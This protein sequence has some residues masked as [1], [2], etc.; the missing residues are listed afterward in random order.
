MIVTFNF[1]HILF[2]YKCISHHFNKSLVK[3]IDIRF[4]Q[5]AD[6]KT[7]CII[8]GYISIKVLKNSLVIL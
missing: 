7:F 8:V 4:D 6:L 2:D 1:G 5:I 3:Q